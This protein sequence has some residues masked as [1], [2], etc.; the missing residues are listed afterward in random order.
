[1]Q[2]G[3]REILGLGWFCSVILGT[4]SRGLTLEGT[5]SQVTMD[6]NVCEQATLGLIM[7]KNS[8]NAVKNVFFWGFG[9]VCLLL[10]LVGFLC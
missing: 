8:H 5:I 4:S 2:L 7:E 1:M 3:N 9:S 6:C 10:V